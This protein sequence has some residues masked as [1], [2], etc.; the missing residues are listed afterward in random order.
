MNALEVQGHWHI[1]K[2]RLRQKFAHWTQDETQF[3][4]GKKDELI[5]SIQTRTGRLREQNRRAVLHV[6]RGNE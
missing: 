2:G 4:A 1:L 6:W 3:M 5:G